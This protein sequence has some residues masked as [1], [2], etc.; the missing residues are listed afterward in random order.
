MQ[1]YIYPKNIRYIYTSNDKKDILLMFD[2]FYRAVK[3]RK[4]QGAGTGLS[5]V[6]SLIEKMNRIITSK[7]E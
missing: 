2:R 3:V 6:K 5:I 4:G 7:F 1:N